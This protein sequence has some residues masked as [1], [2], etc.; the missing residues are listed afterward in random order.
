[1]IKFTCTDEKYAGDLAELA[2]AFSQ[3]TDEEFSLAVDFSFGEGELRVDLLSD[4]LPGFHK[5]ARFPFSYTDETDKK[6]QAKRLIKIAIY[7][8]LVFLTGVELPYGCLTGIRPTKLFRELAGDARETF[9]KD[10]SVAPAKVDLIERT[11]RAQQSLLN[12]DPEREVDLFVN[13]PFCPTRCAYCSFVSVAI[14]RQKALVAPYVEKLIE[15]IRFLK[16]EIASHGK[17]VRAV[18]I[19]G[20]TPTVLPPKLLDAVLSE[21]ETEA[22]E[23]TVEGGRPETLTPSVLALL[24]AHGV[25]RLSVNPQSFNDATLERIGRR[26]TAE[27]VLKAYKRARKLFDVNM[28]LIAML[29]GETFEDFGHSVDTA[30]TLRPANLTVHTLYLK[31]GSELK[32]SGYRDGGS[33]LAEEMVDY[34]YSAVTGEGYEPYYMYR[35]KYTSGNLENVGYALPGKACVY[36]VDIME[37]NT[38]V[39]AAGAGAISKR[40]TPSLGLIERSANFKEPLEYVRHFDE[41]MSRRRAFFGG[42]GDASA[43]KE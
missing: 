42:S 11:V 21:C 24:A 38:T 9:E 28:D 12:S 30:L 7:G 37:E 22:G 32:L 6:R 2:R 43:K 26:H 3:R 8:V 23:F 13:I 35:Q 25:T 41:V 5:T 18:Y 36:N 14:D 17:K 15:E 29:P 31:R 33:K 19:G 4:K 27:Q 40:V 16:G 10:F 34:A 1:M 20:G 39:Y